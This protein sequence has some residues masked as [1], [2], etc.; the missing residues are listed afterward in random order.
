MYLPGQVEK[1]IAK[2][3]ADQQTFWFLFEKAGLQA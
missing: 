3:I 1:Y 2:K